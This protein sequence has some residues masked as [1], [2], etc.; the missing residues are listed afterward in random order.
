MHYTSFLSAEPIDHL[1]RALDELRRIG[2]GLCGV[3]MAPERQ[4][5]ARVRI[6]FHPQGVIAPETFLAR[7]ARIPGV[8]ALEGGLAGP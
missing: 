6:M 2:F 3:E 1:P 5:P 7:V 8:D 4:G